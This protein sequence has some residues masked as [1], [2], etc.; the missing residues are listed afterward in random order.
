MD[1]NIHMLA[2]VFLNSLQEIQIVIALKKHGLTA[3]AA[4]IE[5]LILVGKEGRFSA[6]HGTLLVIGLS[7][8]LRLPARLPMKNKL[9]DGFE[10][11]LNYDIAKAKP[12]AQT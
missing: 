10:H 5:M 12:A 6:G 7:S 9:Q 11:S 3:V 4:I 2:H 8:H 1:Q